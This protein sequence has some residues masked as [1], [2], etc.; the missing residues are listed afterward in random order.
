MKEKSKLMKKFSIGKIGRIALYVCGGLSLVLGIFMIYYSITYLWNYYSSYGMSMS[1]GILDVI[2]YVVT[3]SGIYFGF[4]ILFVVCGIL[5]KRLDALVPK[6]AA[7]EID[8]A[9]KIEVF[10]KEK[11]G[12]APKDKRESED[13]R[14]E[15]LDR[16]QDGE[17]TDNG[18]ES[19]GGKA[20]EISD[21]DKMKTAAL[22]TLENQQS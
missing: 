6:P 21:E 3:S 12:E 17:K 14:G 4:A 5:L 22:E 8:V 11:A 16:T 13:S 20:D 18:S 2:Q 10:D 15:G 7:G 1:D 9:E 19:D